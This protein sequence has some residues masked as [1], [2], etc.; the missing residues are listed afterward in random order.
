MTLDDSEQ[1]EM[2]KQELQVMSCELQVSSYDFKFTSCE[3]KIR[4]MSSNR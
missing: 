1:S 2:V 3:L 4:V